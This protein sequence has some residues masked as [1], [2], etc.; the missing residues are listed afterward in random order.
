M[1]LTKQN[2]IA[3]LIALIVIALIVVVPFV[4]VSQQPETSPV[5]PLKAQSVEDA[6][7][8]IIDKYDLNHDCVVDDKDKEIYVACYDIID[9][10]GDGLLDIYDIALLA[11]MYGMNNRFKMYLPLIIEY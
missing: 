9:T 6:P 1:N 5:S 11:R 2:Y 7:S 10:S 4:Y 3:M 8:C